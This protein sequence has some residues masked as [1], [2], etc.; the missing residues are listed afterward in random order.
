MAGT[1]GM[2]HAATGPVHLQGR[3]IPPYKSLDQALPLLEE[4]GLRNP[5]N[6]NSET[7]SLGGAIYKR[8]RR[9][10]GQLE[11]LHEALFFYLEA[12]KRNPEQDMGYAGVNA[13]F[14]LD[15]LADRLKIIAARSGSQM[16]ETERL[17][18]VA[19]EFR[20]RMAKEIPI[21]AAK[22][23]ATSSQPEDFLDN[24]FWH[25]VTMAEIHFGLKNYAEAGQWLAK[26][27]ALNAREWEKETLFNQLTHIARLQ[28]IVCPGESE[29]QSDWHPPV[30]RGCSNPSALTGS[31][32]GGRCALSM[33]GCMTT[34]GL[35]VF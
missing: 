13:V 17:Q 8:K 11:H 18:P 3:E 27:N 29:P 33:A 28:G 22:R 9:H 24:Q 12:Y 21:L 1:K 10:S 23:N 4:I 6:K 32:M 20:R 15:L 30:Y 35:P 31:L 16:G 2:D 19:S 34:K 14:I 5:D 26:A 7:L 25:L